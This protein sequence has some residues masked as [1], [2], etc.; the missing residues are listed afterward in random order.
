M[1]IKYQEKGILRKTRNMLG[2]SYSIEIEGQ[3]DLKIGKLPDFKGEL[4]PLVD[5]RVFYLVQ[6]FNGSISI[7]ID[8]L[9]E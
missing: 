3:D 4:D 1:T 2:T 8:P 9:D 7:R 5:N 6:T